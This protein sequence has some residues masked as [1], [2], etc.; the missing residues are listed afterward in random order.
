MPLSHTHC[1][2]QKAAFKSW[3]LLCE[4]GLTS[5][6]KD[7]PIPTCQSCLRSANITNVHYPIWLFIPV[8]GLNL[9]SC[10]AQ[11]FTC[12][13]IF[14]DLPKFLK[15]IKNLRIR[16]MNYRTNRITITLGKLINNSGPHLNSLKWPDPWS[17][18]LL[19]LKVCISTTMQGNK[20]FPISQLTLGELLTP[21]CHKGYRFKAIHLLFTIFSR[22]SALQSN[23]PLSANSP[24]SYP[25]DSIYANN[26]YCDQHFKWNMQVFFKKNHVS[27]KLIKN[28]SSN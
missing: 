23:V 14:R 15:S 11:A 1:G 26:H 4:T 21:S 27:K 5:L 16:V 9:R 12:W 10:Q 2:D 3:F 6:L 17:L 13:A 24:V 8:P 19:A 7:S 25:E 28:H 20:L 22:C 18:S